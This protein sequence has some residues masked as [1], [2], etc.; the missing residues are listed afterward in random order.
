M[1]H[2]VT[3]GAIQ[4]MLARIFTAPTQSYE[5]H[6]CWAVDFQ[7]GYDM[8]LNTDPVVFVYDDP[9]AYPPSRNRY[10]PPN[11]LK[12]FVIS[13]ADSA[14]SIDDA[15]YGSF[16]DQ[17]AA[18]KAAG[19]QLRLAALLAS[20]WA[21]PGLNDHTITKRLAAVDAGI[22]CENCSTHGHKNPR[23]PDGR[24]C[25]FCAG[26]KSDWKQYPP[27]D[28]LDIRTIKGRIYDSDIRRILARVREQ[29]K[30]VA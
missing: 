9:R 7:T 21:T 18:I 11:Y 16:T 19:V 22:W 8:P 15:T 2:T 26:F 4:R 3:P 14:G 28:V 24:H 6:D 29:R 13:L 1:A 30:G 20:K 10:L 5:Y 17:L 23:R 27:K 12:A 25:D